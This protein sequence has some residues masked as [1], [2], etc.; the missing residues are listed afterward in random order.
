MIYILFTVLLLSCCATKQK[1]S[2]K[3]NFMPVY[4][5]EPHVL[6]YKTKKNFDKFVPIILSEDK[7]EIISYPHP[8]DLK[9]GDIFLI[10]LKLKEGYLLDNKGI[11]PNVVFLRWTY[12]EY[13]KFESA[14]D[15][16]ILMDNV[17]EKNPLLELCDCGNRSVFNNEIKQLNY[18]I[19]KRV[20]HFKCKILK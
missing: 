16:K 15:L 12:D 3:S 20:L 7:S 14:P 5:M 1:T 2:G 19:K 4:S 9:R 18:L 13:S 8:A 17:I 6:V 10:P 11:S